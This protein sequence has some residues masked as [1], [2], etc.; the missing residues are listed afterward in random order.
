MHSTFLRVLTQ[1]LGDR[2]D[3]FRGMNGPAHPDHRG[4]LHL[5]A[6]PYTYRWM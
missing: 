1:R 4:H 6:G 5:D 2:D 3:V